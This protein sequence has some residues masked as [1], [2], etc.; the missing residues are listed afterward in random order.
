MKVSL[1]WIEREK[2]RQAPGLPKVGC[3]VLPVAPGLREAVLVVAGP[4]PPALDRRGLQRVIEATAYGDQAQDGPA[5]P[6]DPP[7]P[8]DGRLMRLLQ[9]AGIA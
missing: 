3:R 4:N 8:A 7:E 5:P 1:L 2:P 9:S 6:G